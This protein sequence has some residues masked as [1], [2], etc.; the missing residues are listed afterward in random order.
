MAGP[1]LKL[2][3]GVKWQSNDQF[4]PT[5]DFNADDVVF[6]FDRMLKSDH[7]YAK[8]SKGTY[9]TFNTKLADSLKAVSKIDD[10]TVAFTLKEPLAPF[11][12]IMAHQSLAITSAEYAD[13]L[14]KASKPETFDMVPIGTGPFALQAYQQDAVVRLVPFKGNLGCGHR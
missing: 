9:I 11:I 14:M 1:T 5:R 3:K 2:R 6:T 10:Y 13:V 7:P 4:T 12:G 8:I